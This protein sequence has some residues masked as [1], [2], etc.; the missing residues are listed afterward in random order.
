MLGDEDEGKVALVS[1]EIMPSKPNTVPG[2]E[3]PEFDG[4]G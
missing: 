4:E 2:T 1:K 3:T